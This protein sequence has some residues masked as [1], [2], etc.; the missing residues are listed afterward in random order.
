MFMP[1]LSVLFFDAHQKFHDE[2]AFVTTV[3]HGYIDP[4]EVMLLI[5]AY[6]EN[7]RVKIR[8]DVWRSSGYALCPEARSRLDCPPE[9]DTDIEGL[10]ACVRRYRESLIDLLSNPDNWIKQSEPVTQHQPTV[11]IIEPY[12]CPTYLTWRQVGN[13]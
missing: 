4:N 3:K 2:V 13:A 6:I 12:I 5:D 8:T 7:D 10:V 9:A 1:K 11:E